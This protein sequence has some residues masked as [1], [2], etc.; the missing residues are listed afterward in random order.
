MRTQARAR[1]VRAS[2]CAHEQTA[3]A[4]GGRYK[5]RSG[6]TVRLVDLLDE[7]G[8]RMKKEL[9][10]RIKDGKSPLSEDQAAHAARVIG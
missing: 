2:A 10:E 7:A 1:R 4:P 6:D 3:L 9:L 8:E 5:T